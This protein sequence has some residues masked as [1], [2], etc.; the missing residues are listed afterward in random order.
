MID[1]VQLLCSN[2]LEKKS[3]NSNNNFCDDNIWALTIFILAKD[4]SVQQCYPPFSALQLSQK[5]IDIYKTSVS[6]LLANILQCLN[7]SSHCYM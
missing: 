1:D 2:A 5:G 7:F 6:I 4:V 3:R